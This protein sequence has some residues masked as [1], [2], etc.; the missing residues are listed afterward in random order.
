MQ[1]H[2]YS[3]YH[4]FQNKRPPSIALTYYRIEPT[5]QRLL[6]FF[7]KKILFLYSLTHL[8]LASSAL[9]FTAEPP[10][11]SYWPLD[12]KKGCLLTHQLMVLSGVGTGHPI[13]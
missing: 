8:I 10:K 4:I 7:L 11:D 1:K 5:F 2:T 13:H 12:D 6:S 9:L 3:A